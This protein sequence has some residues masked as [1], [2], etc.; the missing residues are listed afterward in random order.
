MKS[1]K[2]SACYCSGHILYKKRRG[3][4]KRYSTYLF[5]DVCVIFPVILLCEK[6]K[7]GPGNKKK[8]P[9]RV[10]GKNITD[11]P[12]AAVDDR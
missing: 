2:A 9:S 12:S 6:Q 4:E 10:G 8:R 7:T 3:R 11:P 5:R 1:R